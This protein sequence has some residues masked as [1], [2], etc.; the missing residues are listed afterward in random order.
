MN[1]TVE[2]LDSAELE[3][4]SFSVHTNLIWE[5]IFKQH[6][7]TASA[8]QELIQNAYDAK[9][10]N[11]W[12]T[13][14]SDGFECRDDGNGFGNKS[15]ITEW[16]EVFGA[17]RDSES[18]HKFGRFRMG[19]GQI[20]GLA[21][22]EWRS[23]EF[24][25]SVDAKNK[26]LDYVL[27]SG[28]PLQKG[29]TI[30]GV[31]YTRLDLDKKGW[32]DETELESLVSF[33]SK[34]VRYIFSMNVFLNGQ[35]ISTRPE[36]FKWTI[37]TDDFYF[38][39][40]EDLPYSGRQSVSVYNLGVL[41]DSFEGMRD[42]GTVVTKKHL[43]L[44]ITRSKVQPD[45]PVLNAIRER[46]RQR[47][48]SISQSKKYRPE[49][50]R[51]IFL[52]YLDGDYSLDDIKGAK[53]IS[54]LHERNFVSLEDLSNK[55]F[56]IPLGAEPSQSDLV[57]QIG[58]FFVVNIRCLP[59]VYN[60]KMNRSEM[61][62]FDRVNIE[63]KGLGKALSN[64]N[65]CFNSIIETVDTEKILLT[66]AQITKEERLILSALNK[67][68]LKHRRKCVLG[69]SAN[70]NGWTDGHSFIAIDRNWLKSIGTGLEMAMAL[71]S[72]LIHEYSHTVGKTEDHDGAFYKKFHDTNRKL[73]FHIMANFLRAY[74]VELAANEGKTSDKMKR[75]IQAVRR[76]GKAKTFG[77]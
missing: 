25:M 15:E 9:A 4:R 50:A 3:E 30:T 28:L 13:L 53:L 68:R 40:N 48:Y 10:S 5:L 64:N 17:P 55:M 33:L 73:Q 37:E 76:G 32:R 47:K 36:N 63:N 1:H 14:T 70:A 7:S 54:D 42:N 56:T 18:D 65:Y 60:D 39:R 71:T 44:N 57:D 59:F 34:S 35:L 27:R 23:S 20:M 72:L 22:T 41:I 16:F 51:T 46:L 11:V 58:K 8:L 21:S 66:D 38:L 26:G 61:T 24:Q 19:R 77:G 69:I 52:R 2:V 12:L 29:C 45:C 49:E 75:A 43:K 31:W 6:H 62:L 74:D 67:V